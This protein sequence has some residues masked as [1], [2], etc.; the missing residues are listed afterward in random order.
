MK[1]LLLLLFLIPLGVFGQIVRIDPNDTVYV[2]ESN[3]IRRIDGVVYLPNTL[4]TSGN[5]DFTTNKW[6]NGTS[7]TNAPSFVNSY[8]LTFNGTSAFVKFATDSI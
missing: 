5:F 1:K 3:Y 2:G 4:F 6:L 8:C 7:E